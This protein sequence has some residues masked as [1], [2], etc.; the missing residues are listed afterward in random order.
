MKKKYFIILIILLIFAAG[1]III[2]S[3]NKKLDL[4]LDYNSNSGTV[5]P[6]WQGHFDHDAGIFTNIGESEDSRNL[7]KG[8][9]KYYRFVDIPWTNVYSHKRYD[10]FQGKTLEDAKNP[11][12]YNFS[13]FDKS[14]KSIEDLGAEP[15]INFV[16]IPETLTNDNLKNSD[17]KKAA[18]ENIIYKNCDAKWNEA[19]WKNWT[20]FKNNPPIDNKIYAEVVS[21]IIA[22]YTE[23]WGNGQHKNYKYFEIGGEPDYKGL[24]NGDENDFIKMYEEIAKTAKNRFGDKIKIGGAAFASVSPFVEKFVKNNLTKDIPMDFVSFHRYTT[25]KND[26]LELKDA[27]DASFA[28]KNATKEYN[29]NVEIF[30]DE[31]GP[32]IDGFET[33]PYKEFYNKIDYALFQGT[34]YSFLQDSEIDMAFQ[35]IIID[36]PKRVNQG[37]ESILNYGIITDHPSKP[38]PVYYLYEALKNFESTPI[39]LKT[40]QENNIYGI[41]AKGDKEINVILINNNNNSVNFNLKIDNLPEQFKNAK[42]AQYELTQDSFD[43][44]EGL[45]LIGEK[46]FQN[47]NIS[48]VL[49]PKSV[50]LIKISAGVSGVYN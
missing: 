35:S 23:G 13:C 15:V 37:Q 38:K 2:L 29:R 16:F 28:I 1:V 45:K 27:K 21:N 30:L 22:H 20:S 25:P 19:D 39:K 7:L 36:T 50:N 42:Y 40:I 5:R 12:F 46:N 32:T 6:L 8:I 47:Q 49:N 18:S 34:V 33:K 3:Q 48:E 41:A 4:S 24:W 31:W 43:K 10:V 9:V 11:E 26:P 14:L 17:Q 44:G